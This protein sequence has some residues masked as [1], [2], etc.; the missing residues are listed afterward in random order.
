MYHNDY[1][2]SPISKC[3]LWLRCLQPSR[4]NVTILDTLALFGG[5]ELS[6]HIS[7]S[8]NVSERP[9]LNAEL[10]LPIFLVCFA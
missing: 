5:S 7:T 8:A 9:D 4:K 2:S 6:G 1:A 10:S 3:V